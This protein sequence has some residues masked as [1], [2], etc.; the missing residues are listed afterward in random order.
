[1]TSSGKKGLSPAGTAW[2]VVGL[3][4]LVAVLAA[5]VFVV[6]AKGGPSP[7]PTS[8]PSP[9]QSATQSATPTPTPTALSRD[10]KIAKITDAVLTVHPDELAQYMTNPV[11]SV[12]F[13]SDAPIWTSTPDELVAQ[14]S[15]RMVGQ[16]WYTVDPTTVQTWKD[17][18][19]TKYFPDGSLQFISDADNFLS[20][21]IEDDGSISTVIYGISAALS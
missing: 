4:A 1:M 5:I 13:A 14:L 19:W 3:I 9:T 16:K 18:P 7:A 11:H 15:P 6:L 10:E 8:S 20:I 17:G 2:L 12:K 21:W